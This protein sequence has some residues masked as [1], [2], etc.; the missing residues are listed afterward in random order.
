MKCQY[1][2]IFLISIV[3]GNA[4]ASG[5]PTTPYLMGAEDVLEISVWKEEGLQKE[6][7]VRPDGAISF[8]LVGD[9]IVAGKSVE[10]LRAELTKK[11]GKFISS[12]VVNVAVLTVGSNKI[13]V[14]G[15]VNNPGAF[16][17]GSYLDIM[18]AL[19]LAGGM[20]PFADAGK[21]KIF[22]RVKGKMTTG[23]FN[24]NNYLKGQRLS[25][26]IMLINGDIVAVP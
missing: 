10:Q 7:L 25:Q 6:I 11:L 16:A 20:T 2:L 19:S 13:Y 4:V 1:F 22:R 9:I 17:A 8:P 5:K 26:N 21:I 23:N 14:I 18:Q 15:K 3:C 12:P 24:Y